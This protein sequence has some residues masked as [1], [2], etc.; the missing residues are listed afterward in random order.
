MGEE[1]RSWI[2]YCMAVTEVRQKFTH[3]TMNESVTEHKCRSFQLITQRM[4][5]SR[6]LTTYNPEVTPNYVTQCH[7]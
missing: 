2:D 4:S 3:E 7:L 1:K 5:E 6:K